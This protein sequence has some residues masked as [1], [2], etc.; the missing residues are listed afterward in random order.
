MDNQLAHHS[1]KQGGRPKRLKRPNYF[2]AASLP[3]FPMWIGQLAS[4]RRRPARRPARNEENAHDEAAMSRLATQ[5]AVPGLQVLRA[6][7]V[8][9][10]IQS[11][12]VRPLRCTHEGKD[13]QS[14]FGYPTE[15]Y[16]LL[17]VI[18]SR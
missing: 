5:A 14:D 8:Q 16:C 4:G 3:P 11:V 7:T 17:T 9:W 12:R 10:T 1:D 2:D 6:A 18:G 15:R 13:Y